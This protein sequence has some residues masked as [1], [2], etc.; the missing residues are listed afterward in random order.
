MKLVWKYI[1]GIT[2]G[3]IVLS[4]IFVPISLLV[5]NN[6]PVDNKLIQHDP[7]M[8][9]DDEDFITYELPG[10]G[11]ANDPYR[12]ENYNI[13]TSDLYSIY[14][15]STTKYFVIENCYLESLNG[16]GYG[17]IISNIAGGTAKINN[18][19][20]NSCSFGISLSESDQNLITNNRITKCVRPLDLYKSK[21]TVVI[22][23][24][25]TCPTEGTFMWSLWLFYCER[26]NFSNNIILWS[27]TQLSFHIA[28]SAETIIVEN[29]LQSVF[30]NIFES[31]NMTIED[32]EGV[33]C[34]IVVYD[35]HNNTISNNNVYS[36]NIANSP[37]ST[38][39]N[40][41]VNQFSIYILTIE[42]YYLYTIVDNW[43]NNRKLSFYLGLNDVSFTSSLSEYGQIY[44]IECINITLS[45]PTLFGETLLVNFINCENVTI[46]DINIELDLS[47]RFTDYVNVENINNLTFYSSYSDNITLTNSIINGSYVSFSSSDNVTVENNQF[48][49]ATLNIKYGQYYN[50]VNN[51]ISGENVF[52][53]NVRDLLLHDNKITNCERGLDAHGIWDASI[54]NN[55]FENIYEEG[56]I[57]SGFYSVVFS[58]NTLLNCPRGVYLQRGNLEQ[59]LSLNFENNYVDGKLIGFYVN[60]EDVIFDTGDYAQ[61][62]FVNCTN[63]TVKDL[64]FSDASVCLQIL[65]C[66]RSTI[67]NVTF[68]NAFNGIYAED[69]SNLEITNNLCNN[70]VNVGIYTF[71][72]IATYIENNTCINS[73]TGI[74]LEQSHLSEITNNT[75]QDNLY[76]IDV[77][78]S[79]N[80]TLDWNSLINNTFSGIILFS[81]DYCIITYNLLEN[82]YY[83][84]ISLNSHSDFNQIYYNAFFNNNWQELEVEYTSQAFDE[85]QNN[86]W[87][88]VVSMEGNFWDSWTG[89]G[90]YEL[91]GDVYNSDPYPLNSSPL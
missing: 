55:T 52:L 5:W 12:I 33:K 3:L 53:F 50:I 72:C 16:E 30:L 81:S 41:Y 38:I 21:D 7:F 9:W 49:N 47:F 13:T 8:I 14:I 22:N 11:T 59:F 67:N 83:W 31:D 75:C 1:T 20:I 64:I 40:N 71:R 74:S 54:V 42:D 34:T 36:I 73:R 60:L 27:S 82:N 91:D 45:N 56:I 46:Y 61:L 69:T 90:E 37:Y 77:S 78:Y 87:Y 26:T 84:G 62:Y 23:N 17:I 24:Y 19:T 10:D 48:N 18:N 65:F 86:N 76:G 39:K 70:I 43:V 32:N 51:E 29:V 15:F 79:N 4:S 80:C 88:D 66:N 89:S 6:K 25:I 68:S 2:V 85:G 28:E 44:F 58:N 63:L 35:S 57:I